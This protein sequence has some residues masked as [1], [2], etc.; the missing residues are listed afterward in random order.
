M[1]GAESL[2]QRRYYAHPHNAFW[3]ILGELLGF[4]AAADY[5]VRAAALVSHG[6]AL[7]DVL[8][9]CERVGS[10]DSDIEARSIVINDFA[11][12]LTQHPR[13]QTVLCNGAAAFVNYRRRVVP[14]LSGWMS[15]L[16]VLQL[17]STSPAHAA[18]SRERKLAAWRSTFAGLLTPA[19]G[20]TTRGAN[21]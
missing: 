9:S 17:P 5:S 1:P 11:Q 2:R 10:L 8:Q 20:H 18:M 15:R 21:G 12:F 14:G 16:P 7:W 6:V 3:P 13:I 4:S 19:A